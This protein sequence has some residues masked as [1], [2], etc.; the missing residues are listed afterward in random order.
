MAR[1]DRLFPFLFFFPP[2][3]FLFVPH[4]KGRKVYQVQKCATG[5]VFAMKVLRKAHLIK[6][7]SVEG[8]KTE[9]DVLR[10]I[11]HPFIVSLHY[12]FQTEGKVYPL[13]AL[14]FVMV[15]GT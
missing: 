7:D 10:R 9:R 12:A 15:C 1:C 2:F 13:F 4:L 11:R 14:L 3:D 8:T 6:T 5:E